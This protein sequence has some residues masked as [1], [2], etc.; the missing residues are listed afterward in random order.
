V[1]GGGREMKDSMRAE[2]RSGV[3]RAYDARTGAERWRWDPVRPSASMMSGAA[4]AWSIMAVDRERHLVFVPTGS[5]SPDYYGGD[6]RGDNKWANF[7]VALRSQNGQGAWAFQLF[8]HGPGDYAP[9]P[10]PPLTTIVRGGSR[11]PVVVIS[12]KTGLVYV[13]N[14]ETGEPV[15]PIEERTAPKSDIAGEAASPTQP[16]PSAPPPL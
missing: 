16:F 3:V 7:V 5:A 12:N 2:V 15:F 4:N 9:A 6:R 14:R 11:V 8:H 10:P 1:G 13:L